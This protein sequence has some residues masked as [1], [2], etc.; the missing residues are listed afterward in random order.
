MDLW[1]TGS[2]ELNDVVVLLAYLLFEA[3]GAAVSVDN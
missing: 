2:G 1:V 3:Y